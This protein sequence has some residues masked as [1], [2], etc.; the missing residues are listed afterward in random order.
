MNREIKFRV[1]DKKKSCYL[2]NL[3]NAYAITNVGDLI[4]GDT[5]WYESL[6]NVHNS[7]YVI[8]QFTGLQDKNGKEIY[9]GDIVKIPNGNPPE[10]DAELYVVEWKTPAW[11]YRIV[12]NKNKVCA[13]FED[14]GFS[15]KEDLAMVIGNILDNPEY[16]TL[17]RI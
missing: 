13:I 16:L 1:W 11:A 3:P 15:E 4:F 12:N 7:Y 2:K 17:R 5:N 9:E 14:I 10:N 6:Q 8:Q